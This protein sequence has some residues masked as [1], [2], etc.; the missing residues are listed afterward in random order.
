MPIEKSNF[1]SS[2]IRI[3]FILLLFGIVSCKD[4][5]VQNA[6]PA[7]LSEVNEWHAKRI[8]NLK[9][10]NGW[11][12][13]AGLYWLKEGENKFGSAK[14]NDVVFPSKAP[15]YVGSFILADSIVSIKIISGVKILFNDL[16]VSEMLLQNDVTENPTIL[17]LGSLRFFIIKRGEKYGVRLRD[18]EAPLVKEFEGIERFPVN[19]A[20]RIE[21]AFKPY[22][23]P[24]KISVPNILGEVE[25]EIISGQLVFSIKNKRF[26]I[27]PINR[28]NRF[29][30]IFSD[31]TNGESTYGAGR[32][33]YIDKPDSLG[34]AILDFNRAYNP[35]C[36]FTKYAT[37][38][39]PP[40]QNRLAVE[41]TAGEKS[42]VGGH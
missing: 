1:K 22:D 5:F 11:L 27:D 15:K 26:T 38:P 36:A 7:Y 23:F 34:N 32:F 14:D 17:K 20:W 12:N 10:E 9:K 4:N 28:G 2:V 29:F 21:A 40:D 13:L 24:K 30:I 6:D 16:V 31:E 37:C 35:P 33:L 8:E 39:L 41:I 19:T 25:D 42:F 18:L 3:V